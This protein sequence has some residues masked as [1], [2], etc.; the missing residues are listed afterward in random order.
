[1]YGLNLWIDKQELDAGDSLVEKIHSGIRESDLAVLFI[2]K[3]TV[4]AKFALHE[5][6]ILENL[7][8]N[9]EKEWFIVK[10]D[11]VNVNDVVFGLSDFLY[12]DLSKE[13]DLEK[14]VE[15]IKR[16]LAKI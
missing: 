12:Y 4:T 11:D 14:L 5:V 10:V 15:S 8:I 16:K 3:A 2:S 9:N 7:K 13:P 6:Q 1:M